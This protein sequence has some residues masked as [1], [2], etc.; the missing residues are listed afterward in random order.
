[1]TSADPDPQQARDP[2]Y[3]EVLLAPLRESAKYTPKFGQGRAKGL[4]LDEF[5]ERYGADPLYAWMGFDSPLLY[6]AHKAAG[7]MTSI[8]R[9]LGIGCER[10]FRQ[11]LRDEFVLEDA[12]V[13]WSYSIPAALGP[14]ESDDEEASNGDGEAELDED[15]KPAGKPRTLALDGRLA[16]ADVDDPEKKKRVQRWVEANMIALGVETAVDGAV[17]E[18]RQGY[19]SKDAKRQNAD[20]ANA[21]QAYIKRYLPVVVIFSNQIDE[22][23]AKRYREGLWGVL[24]GDLTEP[25]PTRSTYAFFHE[26]VGYDLAGFFRRSTTQL[27]TQVD[28]ILV[29]LLTPDKP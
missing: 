26:V 19:K 22:D 15:K 2:D 5:Q 11:I 13:R 28:Q 21:A 23:V 6:A 29:S 27:R 16:A 18:V 7:G 1:M 3:V 4:S 25:D 14:E 24:R 9:Q 12:M 10:L 17:F 20:L 8:Y